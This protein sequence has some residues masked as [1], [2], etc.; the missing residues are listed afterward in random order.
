MGELVSCNTQKRG[1]VAVSQNLPFSN[2]FVGMFPGISLEL[3]HHQDAIAFI[4]LPALL[5]QKRR[6]MHQK[7]F[8]QWL[9]QDLFFHHPDDIHQPFFYLFH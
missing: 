7:S 8:H 1:G 3:S 5:P 6:R 2:V 9:D 4:L